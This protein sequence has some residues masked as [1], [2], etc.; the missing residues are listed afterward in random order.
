MV[1]GYNG[2]GISFQQSNDVQVLNC[3]VEKCAGGGIH[4][5]SGSQ[6][7]VVRGCKSVRNDRDG[8]FFC[9]RVRGAVVEENEFRGNGAAGVSIGHKD[10]DNIIRRNV[11]EDNAGGGVCWRN[12]TEPMAAHNITFEENRL[13][14]NGQ[15]EVNIDGETNGTVIRKNIVENE[16]PE[17]VGV[18]IG[19]KTG[20]VMIEDN[21]IRAASQIRDERSTQS[22]GDAGS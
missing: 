16:D 3:L 12:E 10:S 18:R 8:F 5:G 7:A 15:I 19:K 11:I 4:P 9:W 2:D 6:R 14:N 22:G 20:T 1:R 21:E 13:R 17:A